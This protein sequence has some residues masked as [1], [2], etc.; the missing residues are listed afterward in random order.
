MALR[1]GVAGCSG[2]MGR[3]LLKYIHEAPECLLVSGT[4]SP[5]SAHQGADLGELG[6]FQKMGLFAHTICEDLFE[7]SDVVIDFTK[8]TAT[9]QHA[10]CTHRYRTPLVIGT[11]GL[12]EEDR[13]VIE[14]A[15]HNAAIVMSPNM[16]VGITLLRLLIERS[17]S[18]LDD[19]FDIE[20]VDFHH[21]HKIDTPSGTA[22]SLIKSAVRGRGGSD[23]E[24]YIRHY[25]GPRP[26]G[27]IGLSVLRGGHI[28]GEHS[29]QFIS[30]GELLELRHS[31]FDRSIYVKGAI[32]A[33]F[34]VYDREPGL[35]SMQHVL[36]L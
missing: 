29:V 7:C 24:N 1:I 11:T 17:A 25:Q 36:G 35:Y 26:R 15:S 13:Q 5:G 34:W 28:V 4:V 19:N 14:E 33:A 9:V 16:S 10:I 30:D 6:G 21:R 2:R 8:P 18:I 22:L 31:A 27:A 3:Q 20:V 32:K 23:Y 12:T